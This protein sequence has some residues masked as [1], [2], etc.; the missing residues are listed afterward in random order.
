MTGSYYESGFSTKMTTTRTIP[1][2]SQPAM[3]SL[4][5]CAP[6]YTR[7]IPMSIGST[8]NAHATGTFHGA[9]SFMK[10]RYA[11]RPKV[12]IEPLECPLGKL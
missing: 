7:E 1:P 8:S 5:K 2:S 4:G 11:N 12:I 10:A 9:G 3:T 6:R